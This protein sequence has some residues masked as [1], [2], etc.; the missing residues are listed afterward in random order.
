VPDRVSKARELIRG[1]RKLREQ[2]L[3]LERSR[4]NQAVI[5]LALARAAPA[6]AVDPWSPPASSCVCTQARCASP[7]YAEW[8]R[9]LG[10]EPLFNR[11]HWEYAYAVGVFDQMGAIGE[12]SRGVGFGVGRE[13]L[14]AYLASCGCS[15]LATD[16]PS[17]N[18]DAARWAST[19]EYTGNREGL[20]RPALCDPQLFDS[21][22]TFRPVDMTAVPDDLI[23]FDFCW[24]LCAM[25]H[26]GSLEAGARFVERS[27]QCLRPGGI[28]VHTTEL[29]LSSDDRTLADGPTVL[30]RKRDI[31]SLAARLE[32]KGH[33]VAPLD[34]DAGDGVLDRYVDGRPW[35]QW[36]DRPVL[37]VDLDGFVSTSF[38]LVITAA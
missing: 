8:C 7:T 11:K 21:R 33:V 25:E 14:P 2:Q 30:Y 19:G 32:A 20:A 18:D 9:R 15:V 4:Y 22:V 3:A 6:P 27:L 24:S 28:A 1:M 38:A 13:P 23:G 12:G 5:A 17:T 10:L 16:Q 31:D 26:L 29:N 35:V 36:A 37:R 34:Y